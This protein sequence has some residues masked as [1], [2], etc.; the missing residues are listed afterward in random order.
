M[1]GFPG[2]SLTLENGDAAANPFSGQIGSDARLPGGRIPRPVHHGQPLDA[3]RAH[4]LVD[5]VTELLE[6]DGAN[7]FQIAPYN[8]GMA[9][10]SIP[11]PAN[12]PKNDRARQRRWGVFAPPRP[13]SRFSIG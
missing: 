5:P 7:I 12:I 6:P 3:I 2:K 13:P 8:S 11:G 9:S 10:M 1:E 4:H